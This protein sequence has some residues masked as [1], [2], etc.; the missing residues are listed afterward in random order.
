MYSATDGTPDDWHLVHYGS[1]AQGGAGLICT[2]MTDV[3]DDA[4]ISPGCTG[5]YTREHVEAWRR[6]VDFVHTRTP[7]RMCIQLGHAG[8][9]G[10]TKLM[11]EGSD[12]PL[13][14]GNWPI[15]AASPIAYFP[16][17]QVPRE[18]DR[19]DMDRVRDQHVRATRMAIDAGFD[20][21]ELHMAHGYLLASF[22][23]PLTNARRDRHGGSIAQRMLYPLEVFDAVRAA[24]PAD[25]PISVRISAT[26]WLPG[27]ITDEDVVAAARMLKEHG[28]DVIDVSTGLTTP[29][30]RPPFYGRMYQT[31]W[32]D[33]VRNEVGI[34]TMAVG[35]ITTADQ[36][37]SIL[38]SLRADLCVIARGH[39]RDPHWTLHA[40]QEQGYADQWWPVQYGAARL[41]RTSSA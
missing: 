5:M 21:L 6:I 36:V 9:K 30:S 27:G 20:M 18:M 13:A 26:D 35:N 8:R 11:W 1:R 17:S 25:R 29:T 28:C 41:G 15:L 24:W 23:S 12:Q 16:H 38:A 4:R 33:L 39:L 19:A 22:I 3:A 37:N 14:T 7:A 31:P 40:A 32:S 2:E 10:S 34:P